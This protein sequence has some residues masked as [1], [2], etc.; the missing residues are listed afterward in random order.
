MFKKSLAH[1]SN[2]TPLRSSARRQ[3]VTLILA[4]YPSFLPPRPDVDR[5]EED[6]VF[7]KELGRVIVPEG[8][9]IGTIE[10]SGGVEGVRSMI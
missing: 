9:R 8:V 10:T 4:Q 6:Q 7:E 2:V 1:Q 3:L 5:D